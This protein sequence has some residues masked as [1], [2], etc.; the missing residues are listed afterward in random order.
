MPLMK[1]PRRPIWLKGW[2]FWLRRLFHFD[3]L[4]AL[5][6]FTGVLD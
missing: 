3:A 6:G 2:R 4:S 5:G 1:T